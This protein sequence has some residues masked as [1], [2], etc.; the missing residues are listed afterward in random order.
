[1]IDKHYR[2]LGLSVG[3]SK[4]RIKKAYRKLAMLYHPDKNQSQKA[5]EKF[6]LINE[7]YAALTDDNYVSKPSKTTDQK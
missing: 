1:M 2:T 5:H 7:A 4:E 6:I 3:A